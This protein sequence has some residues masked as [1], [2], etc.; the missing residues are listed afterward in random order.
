MYVCVCH[1]ICYKSLLAGSELD[2]FSLVPEATSLTSLHTVLTDA[3][4]TCLGFRGLG[5][6]VG[7]GAHLGLLTLLRLTLEAHI[8][9]LCENLGTISEVLRSEIGQVPCAKPIY[10][11]KSFQRHR[12]LCPARSGLAARPCIRIGCMDGWGNKPPRP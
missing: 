11:T 12:F 9:C 10:T 2:V 7:F 4:C 3:F 5:P 6:V 1:K 8:P